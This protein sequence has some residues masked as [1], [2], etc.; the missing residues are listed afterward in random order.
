M[1]RYCFSI[2]RY[3]FFSFCSLKYIFISTPL[4]FLYA[5]EHNHWDSFTYTSASFQQHYHDTDESNHLNEYLHSRAR[6]QTSHVSLYMLP[7]ISGKVIIPKLV[8]HCCYLFENSLTVFTEFVCRYVF[9]L[10]TT[11]FPLPNNLA[12]LCGNENL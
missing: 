11:R 5:M 8:Q 3:P 12:A 6:I 4:I 10:E 9:Y 1:P 7:H 2:T